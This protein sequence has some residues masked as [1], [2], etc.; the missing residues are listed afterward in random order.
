[1]QA[2]PWHSFLFLSTEKPSSCAHLLCVTQTTPCYHVCLNSL[3]LSHNQRPTPPPTTPHS[4]TT[5]PLPILLCSD[6][7]P[8]LSSQA[9]A[10]LLCVNTNDSALW[11][12]W[13]SAMLRPPLNDWFL[14][15]AVPTQHTRR[16]FSA[17]MSRKS[18]RASYEQAA[19]WAMSRVYRRIQLPCCS[20]L[21]SN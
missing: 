21:Y 19:A 11:L 7:P 14:D 1:M 2:F 16:T 6:S 10:H 12:A 15:I 17:R 3:S 18:G 9:P 13:E 20:K 5:P 4:H 8:I